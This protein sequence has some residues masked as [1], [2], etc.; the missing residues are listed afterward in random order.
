MK[1]FRMAPGAQQRLLDEVFGALTIAAAQPQ[2]VR[3][4]GV[5]MFGV[6]RTNEV[7]VL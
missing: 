3:E 5:T 1:H 2:R 7:V 4:E 6:Q